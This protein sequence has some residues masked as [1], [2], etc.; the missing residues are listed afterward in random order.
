MESSL[1]LIGLLGW[2]I[3]GLGVLDIIFYVR[4]VEGGEGGLYY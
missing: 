2:S 1:L 3:V 4:R